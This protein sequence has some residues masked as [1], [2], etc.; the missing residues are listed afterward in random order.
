MTSDVMCLENM[1]KN[2]KTMDCAGSLGIGDQR[3]QY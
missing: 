3:I 2:I 1:Y